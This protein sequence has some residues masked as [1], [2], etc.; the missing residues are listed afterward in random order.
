MF[1][2][3]ENGVVTDI[4]SRGPHPKLEKEAERV[5]KLLPKMEPGKQRKQNVKDFFYY[6]AVE[7]KMI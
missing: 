7:I 2:I 4:R 6:K 5:V 1:T 3:D